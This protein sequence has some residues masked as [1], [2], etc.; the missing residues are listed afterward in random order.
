MKAVISSRVL[1]QGLLSSEA[2]TRGEVLNLNDLEILHYFH[3]STSCD[4]PDHPPYYSRRFDYLSSLCYI[5]APNECPQRARP[6]VSQSSRFDY[7]GPRLL[8]KSS[9]MHTC[10]PHQPT[11]KVHRRQ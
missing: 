10:R 9:H 5:T 2:R 11:T 1:H 3:Q 7:H 4:N 6:A 8:F